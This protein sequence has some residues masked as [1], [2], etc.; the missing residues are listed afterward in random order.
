M[1]FPC[2]YSGVLVN[3]VIKSRMTLAEA[4]EEANMTV[5]EFEKQAALLLVIFLQPDSE[6]RRAYLNGYARRYSLSDF[7]SFLADFQSWRNCAFRFHSYI[8]AVEF[9]AA[10]L[11]IACLFCLIQHLVR[12]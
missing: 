1:G 8:A 11:V 12:L 6:Y 3:H 10:E 9:F 4:A 2:A 5:E 7:H